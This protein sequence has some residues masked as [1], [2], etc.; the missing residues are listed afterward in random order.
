MSRDPSQPALPLGDASP[1][2]C[3]RPPSDASVTPIASSAG[4]EIR[5]SASRK[6]RVTPVFDTFWKFAVK[7]QALFMRRILGTPPPWTDDP[8]L[9][10]FRFTNV[11]RAS[12]RVSQFL[13]RH[14]LY[15]G[16]QTGE[17]IFFRCL[18]FKLFNRIETWNE[19]KARL[20]FPGWKSFSVERYSL[21][22]DEMMARNEPVYSAAYIMPTPNLGSPRKHCNHLRLLDRMMRDAIPRKIEQAVSLE[23]VF[24]ALREYPSIGDFLAF[25]YA[26]DLNYSQLIDFSEMDF[27]VAGPGACRGIQKCFNNPDFRDFPRIIRAMADHAQNE[28]GRLGLEFQDLWGRPLQLIDC[29]NLFCEVDKYSRVAHPEFQVSSGRIRIK[30]RFSPKREPLRQWYP[31]KWKLAVPLALSH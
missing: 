8:I 31:P 14:V 6:L 27:V 26:I 18:L 25:Q 11:Y 19:L 5:I 3:S 17:E 20:G 15:E 12:D 23:Q 21:V 1:E 22:L 24:T 13:I 16:E 7:R 4:R 28:F 9:G 10:S 29:Q 30:Q 2:S